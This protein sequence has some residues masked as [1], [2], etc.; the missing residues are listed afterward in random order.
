MTRIQ[1]S[2]DCVTWLHFRYMATGLHLQPFAASCGHMT[3][4]YESFTKTGIYFQFLSKLA[5]SEPLG[6]LQ[7]SWVMTVMGNIHYGCNSKDLQP[8]V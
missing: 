3:A 6:D 2:D 1:S 5:C 4:F 7:L 8:F